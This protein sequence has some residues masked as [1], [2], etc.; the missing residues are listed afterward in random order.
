MI[1]ARE[2]VKVGGHA[3][4]LLDTKTDL[5]LD[6]GLLNPKKLPLRQCWMYG[7]VTE[8]VSSKIQ[9]DLPAAKEKVCLQK[10]ICF[11]P[12]GTKNHANCT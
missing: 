1:R 4:P 3:K 5:L 2:C 9:L 8:I 10:N 7:T 12:K 11:L 6:M